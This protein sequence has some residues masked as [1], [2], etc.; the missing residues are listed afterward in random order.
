MNELN[1]QHA[2]FDLITNYTYQEVEDAKFGDDASD[3][4]AT[5]IVTGVTWYGNYVSFDALTSIVSKP[6][7][8]KFVFLRDSGNT[9]LLQND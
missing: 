7:F 2:I 6:A 5:N 4:R 1:L 8:A 3:Y 9:T